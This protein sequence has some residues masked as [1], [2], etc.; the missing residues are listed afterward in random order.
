MTKLC[1]LLVAVLVLLN[2]ASSANAAII[3]Y[4]PTIPNVVHGIDGLAV[5]GTLLDVRFHTYTE[6]FN[7]LFG[8]SLLPSPTPH[9]WNDLAGAS[10][11]T[12]SIIQ[13]LADSPIVEIGFADDPFLSVTQNRSI[14]LTPYGYFSGPVVVFG[15]Y[16]LSSVIGVDRVTGGM[17]FVD[18]G[19]IG[20]NHSLPHIHYATYSISA[21]PEP[22]S[23]IM[24][25]LGAFVTFS[26]RTLQRREAAK[27]HR[28][29]RK[30]IG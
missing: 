22:S 26:I 11:A 23:A 3:L 18:D 12:Q 13:V 20:R 10:Q 27:H 28:P 30:D 15:D 21:V 6:T 17:L 5:G 2:A 16:T 7:V 14:L 29:K 1:R 9:F 25:S 19:F 8:E 4:D 24:L